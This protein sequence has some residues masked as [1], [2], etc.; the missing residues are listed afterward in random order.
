[1][2]AATFETI[3]YV[4][5]VLIL[6]TSM[7][8]GLYQGVK[9]KLFKCF[10]YLKYKLAG[11]SEQSLRQSSASSSMQASEYLTANSSM[12]SIS[13]AISLL[14]SGFSATSIVGIPAEMYVYGVGWYLSVIGTTRFDSKTNC[15]I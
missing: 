5:V 8:I 1:M 6:V 2:T 12:G 13:I 15:Y 11:S 7:A 4:I 3:D 9:T 10:K 14:A